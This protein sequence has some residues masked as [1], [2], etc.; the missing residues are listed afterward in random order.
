M[1]GKRGERGMGS[2]GKKGKEEK[3]EGRKGE[4]EGKGCV[5][6]VWGIDTLV[7]TVLENTQ[8]SV[9]KKLLMAIYAKILTSF[10]SF[11][12]Y[13]LGPDNTRVSQAFSRI[14]FFSTY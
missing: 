12:N 3:E 4:R 13:I 14:A 10:A 6:A 2:M 9:S 11:D 1:K 8:L 5:M 7:L